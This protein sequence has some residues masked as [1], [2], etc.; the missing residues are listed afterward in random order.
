[1]KTTLLSALTAAFFLICS[2]LFLLR[3]R[4]SPAAAFI[5]DSAAPAQAEGAAARQ[6]RIKTESGVITL[7]AEEYVT[8]VL[9]GEVSPSYSGEVLKAQAVAAYTFACRRA[10]YAEKIG[11]EYDLTDDPATD[12]CY[13]SKSEI[14]E[15]WGEKAE[16]YYAVMNNAVKAVAGE[17]LCCGG[18]TALTVY[19]AISPGMTNSAE[20]VWGKAVP[21][22]VPV[23]SVGDRLSAAYISEAEFDENEVREKLKDLCEVTAG[24]NAFEEIKKN[25]SG[26]VLSFTAGSKDVKG[27]DAAKALSLPSAAFDVSFSEGV[28]RFTVYGRGHGVGMSQTGAEYMARQGSDY[29]EILFHYYKDCEIKK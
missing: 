12:Q 24:Q 5:K 22:L 9:C 14:K 6:F 29:K 20:D 10:E 19:H 7:S 1:M 13:V 26:L 28:Y 3:G 4:I 23:K 25:E 2:P 15:K 8:G 16:E 21:Y 18:E 27:T 17:R 11:R